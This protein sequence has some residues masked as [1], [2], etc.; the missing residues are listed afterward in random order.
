MFLRL[1]IFLVCKATVI[2]V[3]YCDYSTKFNTTTYIFFF[4][5]S[6]NL[7]QYLITEIQLEQL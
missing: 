3:K 4:K 1:T 7:E 2:R 5:L 6:W